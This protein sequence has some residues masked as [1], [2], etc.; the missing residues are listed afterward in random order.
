[1]LAAIRRELPALAQAVV[2][3]EVDAEGADD[4]ADSGTAEREVARA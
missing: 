3:A 2:R 1:M 4:V